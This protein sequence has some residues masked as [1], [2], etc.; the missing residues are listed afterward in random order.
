MTPTFP[1][2]M[3]LLAGDPAVN[4]ARGQPFSPGWRYPRSAECLL[5]SAGKAIPRV[6][7]LAG[8]AG[9]TT[10][11]WY[12]SLATHLGHETHIGHELIAAGMLILAGGG[13]GVPLDYD[14]LGRWTRVGY[15]RGRE[16]GVENAEVYGP[17]LGALMGASVLTID[18]EPVSPPSAGVK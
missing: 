1:K 9:L 2:R 13:R 14:E 6:A 15:E 16:H 17:Y 4:G 18:R 7:V 11:S 12:A 3:T 5:Q 8:A 10:G